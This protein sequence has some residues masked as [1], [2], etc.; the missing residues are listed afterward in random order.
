LILLEVYS[1]SSVIRDP[2]NLTETLYHLGLNKGSQKLLARHV[3][4]GFF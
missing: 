3:F 4:A 2:L 1:M